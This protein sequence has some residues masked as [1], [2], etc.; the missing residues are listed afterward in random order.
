[1]DSSQPPLEQVLG[2]FFLLCIKQPGHEVDHSPQPSGEVKN[3]W[4]Y[5]STPCMCLWCTEAQFFTACVYVISF[6][7][8]EI[9]SVKNEGQSQIFAELWWPDCVISAGDY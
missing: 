9:L 1:M 8:T 4:S 6:A 3:E 7:M 5:I 2:W